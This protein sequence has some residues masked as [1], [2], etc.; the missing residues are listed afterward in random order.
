MFEVTSQLSRD[1]NYGQS[2]VMTN[3]IS[4][5]TEQS[6]LGICRNDQSLNE[7]IW[8]QSVTNYMCL[9]WQRK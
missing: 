2:L 1:Q 4:N 8:I 7:T 5:L 6:F 3:Q 9:T